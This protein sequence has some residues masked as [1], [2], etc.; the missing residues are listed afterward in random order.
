[1]QSRL[2]YVFPE[3]LPLKKARAVQVIHTVDALART[4]V[5]ID[6][7][8]VPATGSVD[9][10]V[11]YGLSC[12]KNVRL[13]P[14][15]RNLPGPL[16][17]LHTHSNRLFLWRLRRWLRNRQEDGDEPTVV[18]VRHVKLAYALLRLSPALPLIYEAHE[19][20]S[21][22]SPQLFPR[23]RAVIEHA[24]ALIA[25]TNRLAN[26]INHYFNLQRQFAIVPSAT[27]LPQVV[28]DGKNWKAVAQHIVYTGS[29]YDWKGVDDLIVAARKL[30]GCRITVIGGDQTGIARLQGMLTPIGAQVDFTGHLSH[31]EVQACLNKACIAVLPNRVGSISEFT[32]PL[33]LFEYMASG[34]A[35][36]SSDLP[37]VREILEEN[38]ASWFSP[39]DPD[40]LAQAIRRLVYDPS[41]A[42]GMAEHTVA[43][44]KA[45]SWDGRAERLLAVIRAIKTYPELGCPE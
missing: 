40:G 34:C 5:R 42:R 9:P 6:F 29:L 41:L 30:P 28:P 20:F 37:V 38:E 39:N 21:Q 14:L 26:A 25:I 11:H 44:A 2:L 33:K 13:V 27:T 3:P 7:A 43:K 10:F 1:M 18:F 24:T 4:G 8:Y 12:P 23:E 45:Y 17:G 19:I 36:V 22:T 32:S 16:S 15:S 35:I 31:R